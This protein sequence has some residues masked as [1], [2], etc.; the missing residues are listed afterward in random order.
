MAPG[1]PNPDCP[2][3]PNIPSEAPSEGQLQQTV[4][5]APSCDDPDIQRDLKFVGQVANLLDKPD[6]SA[7][8]YPHVNRFKVA[9]RY[10]SIT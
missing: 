10:Y 2:A 6:V 8:M 9:W 7:E 4:Y 1:D 3:E 5:E